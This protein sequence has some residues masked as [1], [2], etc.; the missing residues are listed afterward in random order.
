M[1]CP[2]VRCD[3]SMPVRYHTHV[4]YINRL[5]GC[6]SKPSCTVWC[7]A[8]LCLSV[9]LALY[10][11]LQYTAPSPSKNPEAFLITFY[12][13]LIPFSS[14][15]FRLQQLTKVCVWKGVYF[16]YQFSPSLFPIS[17]YNSNL[18][19]DKTEFVQ[20]KKIYL[21]VTYENN[22]ITYP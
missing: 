15:Y 19:F 2:C 6:L 14:T 16:K 21:F 12:R 18:L 5:E 11:F 22:F 9:C 10:R 13:K 20:I 8:R 7:S 1:L 4:C 17:T 3:S